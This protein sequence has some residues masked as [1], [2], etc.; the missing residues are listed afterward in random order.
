MKKSILL[1]V[2]MLV[3]AVFS[4]ERSVNADLVA[5][6][7]FYGTSE[8]EYLTDISG[9]N[10]TASALGNYSWVNSD[11]GMALQSNDNSLHSGGGG[12]KLNTPVTLNYNSMTVSAWFKLSSDA[13]NWRESLLTV[14][15]LQAC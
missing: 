3:G 5:Y 11:Y 8:T 4:V 15:N 7:P 13:V 12:A 14:L 1:L 2:V 6:L 9:N 10:I